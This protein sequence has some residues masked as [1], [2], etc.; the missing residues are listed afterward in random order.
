MIV[1]LSGVA[2]TSF[3]SGM[4]QGAPLAQSGR[5]QCRRHAPARLCQG[6]NS[7]R[8]APPIARCFSA[9]VEFRARLERVAANSPA[10]PHGR[11][12]RSHFIRAGKRP[13]DHGASA[14]MPRRTKRTHER[15]AGLRQRR[16]ACARFA[17][18]APCRWRWRI[19]CRAAAGSACCFRCAA[20]ADP[21]EFEQLFRIT[22]FML[23][24]SGKF[25]RLA[26]AAGCR[27]VVFIGSLVRP[28]LWHFRLDFKT[29]K[30]L[31]RVLAAFRGGDDH[32]LSSIARLFEDHGFRLLGAHEVAPEILVPEGVLGACRPSRARSRRYRFGPRLSARQRTVR[33]RAGRGGGG[34]ARAGGGSGGRHRPDAGA[35]RGNAR[36]RPRAQR[37]RAAG[38]W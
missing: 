31:P 6:R 37:R 9:T 22:G 16:P 21:A 28:S 18:A 26:R 13:L 17:A 3:R 10:M 2:P 25:L 4:A 36:Q 24:Q 33:R 1:G 32:L 15:R 5:P 29:L 14:A 20:A 34:Q 38:C 27:D 30:F 35:R 7:S 19:R 11:Q 23:G 12:D 8:V